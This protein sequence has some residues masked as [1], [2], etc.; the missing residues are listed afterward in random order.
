MEAQKIIQES[1]L[2]QED[3]MDLTLT[4]LIRGEYER[5]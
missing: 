5:N 2:S 4:K 3:Q 1:E